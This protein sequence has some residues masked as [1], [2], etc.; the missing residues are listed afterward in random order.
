MP[1]VRKIACWGA[2]LGVGLVVGHAQ[3]PQRPPADLVLTHGKILT[4]DARDTIAEAIAIR[5]GAIAAVG[6]T[7]EIQ[8]LA[9]PNT[10]VVDL[11]GRAVTPGLIDTHVHFSAAAALYMIDL[12]DGSIGTVAA[13]LQRVAERVK[14]ARP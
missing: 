11:R 7:A 13:A 6:S 12:G 9:G 1:R 8:A 14:T 10:R 3:A 4:V 5:G 2:A